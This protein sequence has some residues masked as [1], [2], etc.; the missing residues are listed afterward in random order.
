MLH[1]CIH[2]HTLQYDLAMSYEDWRR[3]IQIKTL[4]DFFV[5]KFWI[6][7]TNMQLKL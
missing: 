2:L 5:Q 4:F 3:E 6:Q 7:D 1:K